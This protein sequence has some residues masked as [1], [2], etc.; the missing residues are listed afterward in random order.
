MHICIMNPFDIWSGLG[1]NADIRQEIFEH[2]TDG[3][4]KTIGLDQLESENV[5][6]WI[7]AILSPSST[8]ERD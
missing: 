5:S 7:W 2:D 6:F 1:A 8:S 4:G 3:L